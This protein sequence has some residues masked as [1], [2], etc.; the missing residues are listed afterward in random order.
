MLTVSVSC[1]LL[2]SCHSAARP[3]LSCRRPC[4]QPCAGHLPCQ[5]SPTSAIIFAPSGVTTVRACRVRAVE[6]AQ[7]PCVSRAPGLHSAPS[8]GHGAWSTRW[9]PWSAQHGRSERS[10]AVG[11]STSQRQSSGSGEGERPARADVGSPEQRPSR[12]SEVE[13]ISRRQPTCSV[14]RAS[15]Q[16]AA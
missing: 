1:V 3:H 5:P 11:D 6:L 14:R 8:I 2:D 16:A 15:M 12:A 7:Q 9:S 13:Y 4:T 10:R